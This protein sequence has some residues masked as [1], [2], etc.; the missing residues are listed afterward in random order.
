MTRCSNCSGEN[1]D[2][3]RF[4]GECGTPL[5]VSAHAAA[6]PVV[7]TDETIRLPTA[8]LTPGTVFA[9][10]YHVIEPLGAGGMGQVY[11]VHDTKVGE[12][13]ALKFI[14]AD[15]ASDRGILERFAQE[16]GKGRKVVHRNVAR[17]FDLNEE[18]Q[19]PYFTMEY[20]RGESLKHLLRKVGHL[21]PGQAIP[22]ACQV[23][24]GLEAIH[25]EG[26]VHHDL[27]PQNVMIDED[28]RAKILDFGLARPLAAAAA[29]SRASRSG[30]PAYIAPEQVAGLP[31]DHRADIYSLGIVLYEM[32]TGRTPFQAASLDELLD[33]H[34][35]QK[36]REPRRHNP[37]ISPELSQV[38]MKCLEK[39]PDERFQT[40]AELGAALEG[41]KDLS[42]PQTIWDKI[43]RW[44]KEHKLISVAAGIAALAAVSLLVWKV[45]VPLLI[46]RP[47]R[48]S[49]AVLPIE[50]ISPGEEAS[51]NFLKG[52]QK[53]ITDR[54][55]GIE[56]LRV[57][58]DMTVNTYDLS[59]MTE[60]QIG[61]TLR[62][63]HLVRVTVAIEGSEVE[64]T[65]GLID[66]K[67]IER[68]EPP[69][70]F[71]PNNIGDFRTLQDE[72]A[73][74]IAKALGFE[75]GPENLAKFSRR[76]TKSLE[77]YGL[78]LEGMTLLETARSAEEIR[79][80]IE[81]FQRAVELDPDY[82][83]GH[84]GLGYGYEHL[85]Y[86]SATEED[87][88]VLDKMYF[89]LNWASRLDPTFAETNLGLGWYFFNKRDN[90]R[91][92]ESFRK[93]LRL[94]PDGYLVNRDTGAFLRSL[95]LYKQALRYLERAR[96]LAP[97]DPEPLSQMAQ[98]WMFLGRVEKALK[99][100][101]QALE[102][103]AGNV[104]ALYLHICLLSLNG[105]DDEAE[106]QI[107]AMER[108]DISNER[109][110]FLREAASA[111]RHGRGRPYAFVGDSPSLAPQG[112]YLYLAFDMKDRAI[113]NIQRGIE[114]GFVGGMYHYSY[115]SL[116]ENPRY[117]PLR[118]DPR[119]K[120]ILKRQKEAYIRELKAFEK[121]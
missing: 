35:R 109:L 68:D 62:A 3:Q 8:D 74:M 26:I 93:A 121:L 42:R 71:G 28:G 6:P 116:V 52:L 120:E 102:I 7:L 10:R 34:L 21:A 38:A 5:P 76:G 67:R 30:T 23:C 103:R 87:A 117:K 114:A 95:G 53:E 99:Y 65:V 85:Y 33:M 105:R 119:F 81:K 25:A 92:F 98:C 64:G 107:K 80:S 104:D 79:S 63:R 40:A 43:V 13:V 2:T 91:A 61:R 58:G 39:D 45:I 51:S 72:L 20:V 66:V 60:V 55:K 48:P 47:W 29:G 22:I 101:S 57:V 54:L 90:A 106:S 31:V 96:K 70:D 59:R 89:H 110:P 4:C 11:R 50:D 84:W 44:I 118:G 94:E 41:L 88:E 37:G 24:A 49:V 36:P 17:M 1:P 100:T 113:A 56:G 14:R 19:V 15:A 83:L 27:K 32:L 18:G 112:T 82:A 86:D 9:H 16:L 115:P 75:L 46:E 108:F 73:L 97:R 77:A 69:M 78:F 12:E 111:L